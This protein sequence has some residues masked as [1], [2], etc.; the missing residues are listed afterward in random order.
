MGIGTSGGTTNAQ[1]STGAPTSSGNAQPNNIDLLADLFGGSDISSPPAASKPSAASVSGL[2]AGIGS[3][4]GSPP[5]SANNNILDLLGGG[6][7]ASS[8]APAATPTFANR[9]TPSNG[10]NTKKT[11]PVYSKNGFSIVFTPQRDSANPNVVN[12]MATFQND[13]SVSGGAISGIQFHAAVTKVPFFFLKAKKKKFASLFMRRR[14]TNFLF[15]FDMLD[16]T[17]ADAAS[18]GERDCRRSQR[19]SIAQ[20]CQPP[21]GTVQSNGGHCCLFF[22]IGEPTTDICYCSNLT[23]L[24]SAF[25]SRL[26]IPRPTMAQLMSCP[27]LQASPR[28]PTNSI[29]H[30]LPGLLLA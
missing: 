14:P 16:S 12:I 13:P 27:S 11:F 26:Y 23:R 4:A 10:A 6:M 18:L 15:A 1:I 8:P 20:D 25:V 30:T 29:S 5:P 9:P 24:L 28:A 2:F 19:Y 7:A 22:L 3:P 21:K 17:T